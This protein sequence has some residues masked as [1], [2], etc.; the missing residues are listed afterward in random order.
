MTDTDAQTVAPSATTPDAPVLDMADYFASRDAERLGKP[1]QPLPAASAADQPADQAVET[2]TLPADGSDP[3]KPSGHKGN[4]ASRK[5]DVDAEIADLKAKLAERAQLRSQLT[6]PA[7]PAAQALPASQPATADG[8]REPTLADFE[9]KPETYPD[10]YAA[11]LEARADWKAGQ[12][13]A[14]AL[15]AL[16]ARTKAETAERELTT[17]SA[18]CQAK[19]DAAMAADPS[20]KDRIA[21]ERFDAVPSSQLKPG[22]AVTPQNDLAE[23]VLDADQPTDLMVHLSEQPKTLARL[24]ASP[25]PRAFW[26][27]LGQI[28]GAMVAPQRA[29]TKTITDAPAPVQPVGTR[30]SALSDSDA[31]LRANDVPAYFAAR[32]RE[33]IAGMR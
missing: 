8:E 21:F 30:T 20:L 7:P 2:A 15:A 10:P 3:S 19:V 6:T 28:E 27:T 23:A 22:E 32:D 12:A 16:D 5:A 29:P 13:V 14:K 4:L 1:A 11:Y 33:R 9:A 18:A 24:L 31:A 17:R 26:R 25:N